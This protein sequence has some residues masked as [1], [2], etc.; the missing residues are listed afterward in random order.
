MANFASSNDDDPLVIDTSVGIN[1]TATGIGAQL[2]HALRRPA[3]VVQAVIDELKTGA[4]RGQMVIAAIEQWQRDGLLTIAELS[5]PSLEN[6][7]QLIS[8][9]AAETLDDGEAATIAHTLHVSGI[10]V[11]DDGKANRIAAQRFP[12]MRRAATI[13]LLLHDHLL[14][15]IGKPAVA[16]AV[17]AA[18]RGARMRIPD[19]HTAAVVELL[20]P[21]RTTLCNSLRKSVRG[22]N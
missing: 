15:S 9:P 20:G 4:Q 11:V 5:E 12:Q 18:L 6:F 19:H 7:E 2:L 1:L 22:H 3:F 17:Y 8:G 10:A 14:A 13:E 21:E 16:D